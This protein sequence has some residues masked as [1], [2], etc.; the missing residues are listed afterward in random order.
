MPTD[1]SLLRRTVL[2]LVEAVLPYVV[3]EDDDGYLAEIRRFLLE[4]QESY[5]VEELAGLWRIPR[6]DMENVYRDERLDWASA[7]PAEAERVRIS[8]AEAVSTAL[9]FHLVRPYDVER[10]LGPDFNRVRPDSWRTIPVLI[11]LPAFITDALQSGGTISPSQTLAEHV[12]RFILELF[13]GEH[14]RA[15]DAAQPRAADLR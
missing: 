14:R 2:D 13:E 6:G 7:H 5:S 15:F 10:A 3:H 4:P 12:E 1:R 11:R 8:W 9:A